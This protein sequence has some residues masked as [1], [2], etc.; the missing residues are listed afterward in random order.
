MS[1]NEN[2]LAR[3]MKV[4]ENVVKEY[5][6]N[7]SKTGAID[8]KPRTEKPELLF[9][10]NRVD[11]KYLYFEDAIY[12][13]RKLVARKRLDAV[14][15]FVNC[16]DRCRSDLLLEYFGEKRSKSC[17]KC[18]VCVKIH[19]LNVPAQEFNRIAEAVKISVKGR[20]VTYRTTS[21]PAKRGS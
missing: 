14:L 7:L 11:E 4:D 6:V 2:L 3:R 21:S 5:L 16:T 8:Y 19:K 10:E 12:K 20:N 15:N 9:I 17:G 1:I 18:D 13:Q